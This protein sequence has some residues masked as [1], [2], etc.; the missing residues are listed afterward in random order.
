MGMPAYRGNPLIENHIDDIYRY[1]AARA[2][3]SL[4]AGAM[5]GRE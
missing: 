4:A 1:F 3:G 2:D 5:P